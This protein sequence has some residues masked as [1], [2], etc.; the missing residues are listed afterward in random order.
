LACAFAALQVAS[1]A[2]VDLREPW[3]SATGIDGGV[4]K[5]GAGGAAAGGATAGRSGGVDA[6]S[7]EGGAAGTS[8]DG[9]AGGAGGEPA[10]VDAAAGGSGGAGGSSPPPP[11]KPTVTPTWDFEGTLVSWS[12]SNGTSY[13]VQR[14][15]AMTGPFKDLAPAVARSPYLDRTAPDDASVFYV[16]VAQ[17]NGSEAASAP[18]VYKRAPNL[19]P[20]ASFEQGAPA[21]DI[22]AWFSWSPD[23]DTGRDHTDSDF[24]AKYGSYHGTHFSASPYLAY[25]FTQFRGLAPGKFAASAWVRSSGGQMSALFQYKTCGAMNAHAM[26]DVPAAPVDWKLVEL[27]FTTTVADCFEIGFLSSANANQWIHFDGVSLRR[28]GP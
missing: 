20:N 24:G 6:S 21:Q 15:T 19:V 23:G 13:R 25:T 9:G 5:G 26:V 11:S 7:V 10:D 4:P 27:S 1:V 12:G 17:A 3:P 28:A 18:V 2:C 16:V 22:P 14:G 8:D